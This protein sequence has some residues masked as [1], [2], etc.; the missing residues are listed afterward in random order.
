[1]TGKNVAEPQS[2]TFFL[3]SI[4]SSLRR[5][6][7]CEDQFRESPTPSDHVTIFGSNFYFIIKQDDSLKGF[8]CFGDACFLKITKNV[9]YVQA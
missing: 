5:T 3:T 9:V 7:K 4:K 8:S 1:M 6:C 2:S